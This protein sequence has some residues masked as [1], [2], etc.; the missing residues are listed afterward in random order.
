MNKLQSVAGRPEW[1]TRQTTK[2]Q[3]EKEPLTKRWHHRVPVAL[4][5]GEAHSCMKHCLQEHWVLTD[6]DLPCGRGPTADS[7]DD[8][9]CHAILC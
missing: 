5:A 8:V 9:W 6:V 2:E 7:L 3:E 4:V 1:E